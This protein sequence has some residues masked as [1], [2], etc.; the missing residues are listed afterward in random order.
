MALLLLWGG[1]GSAATVIAGPGTPETLIHDAHLTIASSLAVRR[2][3]PPP[4]ARADLLER[5]TIAT[6]Y[7]GCVA[8]GTSAASAVG[9]SVG[10][11][12]V[13][14]RCLNPRDRARAGPAPD[15]AGLFLPPPPAPYWPA[16]GAPVQLPLPGGGLSG[17]RSQMAPVP[18][19]VP[20]IAL[21]GALGLILAFGRRRR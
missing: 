17:P 15:I 4:P 6:A 19:P 21:A 14:A 11:L 10:Y 8:A 5:V 20:G 16:R 18:L 9:S 1:S 3:V 12:W 2:T 7:A 13:A